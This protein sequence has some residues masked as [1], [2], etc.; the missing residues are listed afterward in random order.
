MCCSCPDLLLVILSIIFPP[1]GALLRRGCGADFLI[2]CG[3][4]A[5][6][7]LPGLIHAWYL[8]CKY[9]GHDYEMLVD[10][11]EVPRHHVVII[12]SPSAPQPHASSSANDQA[13]PPYQ[14]SPQKTAPST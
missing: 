1:F 6:G 13:P 12:S 2:N 3:L 8:I 14:A 5:L 9:P 11:E 10:D 4:T 7:Y